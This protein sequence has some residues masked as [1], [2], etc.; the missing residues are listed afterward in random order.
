MSHATA[1]TARSIERGNLGTTGLAVLGRLAADFAA[2]TSAFEL[3]NHG[4]ELERLRGLRMRIAEAL[5]D[6]GASV[7]PG[8]ADMVNSVANC[9]FKS[10][11]RC[12][13]RTPDEDI[14]FQRC[15]LAMVPWRADT[16]ASAG[17]A[18]LLLSWHAFELD[19]V[20]ALA[21][22]PAAIRPSWLA[23]LF[24]TPPAFANCGDAN[25]MVGYLQQLC[26]RS[27]EILADL[28]E[29]A[30]DVASSFFNSSI[31]MQSYFNELNLSG[32]MR[33][34]A[35][36]IERI[37]ERLDNALDE[38]RLLRPVRN[39]PRIGFIALGVSDGTEGVHLAAHMERLDRRRYE[40]RLYS[41]YEPSGKI[42]ALCRASAESYLQLP[43]KTSEAV[44]RLR[45]ED[46]DMAL[47]AT[48]LT[49][50]VHPLTQIAAHRI[51]PIQ[52]A[53][54]AS[55][56]TT[57]LR[58]VDML[59]SGKANETANSPAHYTE[60]LVCF[61]GTLNCYPFHRMLEGLPEPE[62]VSRAML[63]IPEDVVLF[64][65]AANYY[66]II[67]ELS[68]AWV[69][70]LAE[71]PDSQLLLMPYNP[72]WSSS[73]ALN[74]FHLRLL[75]Q[76]TEAGVDPER[77]RTHPSVAT[78]AQL[79]KLM[80]V[81]D[82]YLDAFPFSGACSLYDALEVGLPVVAHQGQVCRSRHS[83]AILEQ[84][85]L[86]EWAVAD[87]AAYVRD[88]VELG[89]DPEKR[90]AERSK[91]EKARETGFNLS[92][93]AA[94]AARLMPAL[95]GILSD[96][97]RRVETV[98]AT[99]PDRLAQQVSTLAATAAERL[100]FF[101]DTDLIRRIVL[102]Y[103]RGGGSRRLIDVG[104][105]MGAM[106][107]PFLDEGWQS[108]MFE[109][110]E[111]CRPHLAALV[112]GYP[113]QARHEKMAVTADC[114]GRVRFHLASQ[115]GLSGLSHSPFAGDLATIEVPA[116][117]LASYIAR[118]GLY[119]V[120]FVKIDAEGHDFAILGG[121]DFDAI[122]PRLVMVE[123]GEQ[124]QGQDRSSVDAGLRRM[125]QL[126]YRAAV[127]CQRAVGQF[128][129]HEWQTRLLAAA[130]D[131]VPAVPEGLP[132]FGN[133]L[134]FREQDRDFVPSLCDWLER[135]ASSN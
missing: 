76:A 88:A 106:T 109:P 62:P 61:S 84:A 66:K 110:D 132:I 105:C 70:I 54:S 83:T 34:R 23:Y 123:F 12:F 11:I 53:T 33:A 32:P 28:S 118:H 22:I 73:Y 55:P 18:A 108:V 127:V 51:A 100:T 64:F 74:S 113:G 99:D 67:P 90:N 38:L 116:V 10:G 68:L 20:P 75:R 48:N 50:S 21:S 44:S 2:A 97:D 134:F 102:P 26:D 112:G 124:F 107:K 57:G 5:L 43:A 77:I 92:D 52:G 9:C 98:R 45:R 30:N 49:A 39:R 71:V 15:R 41:V 60:R 93:T 128:K 37:L 133:V 96:W 7:G 59:F 29:P 19:F 129:R 78:V 42:G 119:D 65:S 47:F 126:G 31:F 115:P 101:A 69:Q 6:S 95:D 72:N 56:V 82:I 8:A 27:E 24:E 36:V 25:R 125:R 94:F 114:D 121:I 104:A 46:L 63:G 117:A 14:L 17:L 85:G 91:L 40:I 111:R 122:T 58:N 81:A 16:A 130:I 79:H 13:P 35:R 4:A 1:A 103:L 86:G 87:D 120:D 89:L 3:N 131:A 135:T 80:A